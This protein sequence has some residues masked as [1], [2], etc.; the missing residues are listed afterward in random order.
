MHHF[1]LAS[2]DNTFKL[3][4]S[5]RIQLCWTCLICLTVL[6]KFSSFRSRGIR[7]L[8]RWATEAYC[9][10][11]SAWRASQLAGA[12]GEDTYALFTQKVIFGL[13]NWTG[14]FENLITNEM[15]CWWKRDVIQFGKGTH[16]LR[17]FTIW[18][19][20]ET[21]HVTH[22]NI[23]GLESTPVETGLQQ[24]FST[25]G[26]KNKNWETKFIF[27]TFILLSKDWSEIIK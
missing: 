6:A 8:L 21:N 24:A 13:H 10:Q 17:F 7:T 20:A 26:A 1:T 2:W 16:F 18:M 27:R 19:W 14:H 11:R 3:S 9:C 15:N 23:T 22:S 5:K 25:R 4:S 12:P